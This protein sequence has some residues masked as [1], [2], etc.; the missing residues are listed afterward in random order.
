MTHSFS[1][2][3]GAGGGGGGPDENQ[4]PRKLPRRCDVLEVTVFATDGGPFG[5]STDILFLLN[6]GLGS[7]VIQVVALL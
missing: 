3:G 7:V 2:S 6:I 1:G 4:L 5:L